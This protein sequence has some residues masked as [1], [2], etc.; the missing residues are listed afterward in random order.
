LGDLVIKKSKKIGKVARFT[1]EE[2]CESA[3]GSSDY[4]TL[5]EEFD[6]LFVDNIPKMNLNNRN[7]VKLIK[8]KDK[9]LLFLYKFCI[10]LF[11]NLGYFIFKFHI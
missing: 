10:S 11:V 5:A 6:Y 9:F 2:L 8:T 7:Q 4:I 1:F 3:L